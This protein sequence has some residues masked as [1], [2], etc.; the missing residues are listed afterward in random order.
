MA[1]DL[2]RDEAA[3]IKLCS[4]R[5]G[6]TDYTSVIFAKA[7]SGIGSLA[8]LRG[9]RMAWVAKESSAGYVVP[10]L[11][12]LAEGVDPDKDLSVQTFRRTHEAVV[13]A[14][15]DGD[16]DAGA[17][18]AS[19]VEGQPEPVSAGWSEA[20]AKNE[21]VKILATAGPIP[22]D[23]IAFSTKLEPDTATSITGAMQELGPSIKLLL[24]ADS[25]EQPEASHFEDLRKL[26]SLAKQSRA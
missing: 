15:L 17:T 6:R 13:R 24:N 26:V 7:G 20:H 23:V 22:S 16:A 21:D 2:E 18:Y 5:A 11:K 12:L 19:F 9:K 4:R 10:R 25:F 14:V 1:L 8:E 3:E